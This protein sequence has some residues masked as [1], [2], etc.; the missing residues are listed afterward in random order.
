MKKTNPGRAIALAERAACQRE[1]S[2]TNKQPCHESMGK[3]TSIG[4]VRNIGN[5][6][7]VQLLFVAATGCINGEQNGK[8][9]AA[10]HEADHG[11]RLQKAQQEVGIHRMMLQNI[12]IGQLIHVT[13]PIEQTG[14]GRGRS[15]LGAQHSQVRSGHV[16]AALTSAQDYKHQNHRDGH[17]QRRD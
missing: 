12:F 13:N 17:H 7:D 9:H 5:T 1:P 4:L 14:R 6:Q 11:D 3:V 2:L 15:L 8:C 16:H 10:A